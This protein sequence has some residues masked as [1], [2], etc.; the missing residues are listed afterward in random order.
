[1]LLSQPVADPGFPRRKGVLTPEV[2]PPPQNALHY[3]SAFLVD[4]LFCQK[5]HENGRNLS[6]M[7][8]RVPLTVP[9]GSAI[10]VLPI[11]YLK[12]A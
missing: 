4:H 1:M 3:W 11:L 2:R 9:P 10:R 6:T 5:L 7:E 12:L 8:A